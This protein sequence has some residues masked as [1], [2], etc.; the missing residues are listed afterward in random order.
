MN[1]SVSSLA[2]LNIPPYYPIEESPLPASFRQTMQQ[3]YAQQL[4][5]LAAKAKNEADDN[6]IWGR[7]YHYAHERNA[8]L[9]AWTS[10]TLDDVFAYLNGA[11]KEPSL[12]L[13]NNNQFICQDNLLLLT[14][15]RECR[16]KLPE[17]H[18][19]HLLRAYYIETNM[20]I[21]HKL[22]LLF[23]KEE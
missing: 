19:W 5:M 17:C 6:A 8:K 4:V 23:E 12:D 9:K 20:Q 10:D 3:N 14:L 18:V 21:T 22:D 7:N 15:Y 2:G 16:Q 1:Q 11:E 13:N